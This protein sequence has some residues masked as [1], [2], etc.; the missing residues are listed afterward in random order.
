MR[1]RLLEATV[2]CLVERGW[3][4]TSTTVVSQ[5]AGVSR[6]AQLHHFPTKNA[7]VVAAVEHLSTARGSERAAAVRAGNFLRERQDPDGAWR[8]AAEYFRIPHTYCARVSWALLRLARATGDASYREVARR[9]L[10]WVA[11]MQQD[12]G[13]FASCIRRHVTGKRC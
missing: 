8:G 4:G 13:W 11:G 10:D 9:Q 1:A 2:E 3:S 12:N 7:L 6:G 5:R